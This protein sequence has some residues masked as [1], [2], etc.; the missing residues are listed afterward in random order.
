MGVRD[1]EGETGALVEPV[2]H[3]DLD[4][5][6]E[7]GQ[8][9]R[10]G[11]RGVEGVEADAAVEGGHR[12]EPY[13]GDPQLLGDEIPLAHAVLAL[14]VE[15]D[16]LA[17]AEPQLAQDVGLLQRRL[18]VAGL[19]EHQ[20][21]RRGELLPVQLEGVVDV[22]LA[23]VH[24]ASD[25]HARVAQAGRG[26]GQVDGLGLA[27]GGPYGQ[28]GRLHLSEEEA[29]E[30]LGHCCERIEH[31]LPL[32]SDAGRERQ[33]VDEGPVVLAVAPLQLEIALA[34]RRPDRPLV[35]GERL[36]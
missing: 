36:G 18:A 34:R 24:L 13:G 21:V 16:H 6:T 35:A 4:D 22:P 3:R 29:G 26:R 9:A 1:L 11:D 32:S 15:D 10:R 7:Q 20:P 14:R 27:G 19:A 5:R 25:D 31:G 8:L 33:R 17:V 12:V 23:A 30:R 2:A 28:P